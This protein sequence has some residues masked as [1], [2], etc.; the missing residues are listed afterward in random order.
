VLPVDDGSAVAKSLIQRRMALE[1]ARTG[2]VGTIA[3]SILWFA[4]SALHLVSGD[5]GW[6]GGGYLVFG[7]LWL[8][9]GIRRLRTAR[10]AVQV[11]EAEHGGNAGRR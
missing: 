2:A 8:V 1:R 11:F 4:L 5:A 10:R 6:L 7:L 9:L 3:L